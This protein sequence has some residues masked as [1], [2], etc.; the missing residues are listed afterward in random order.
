[1]PAESRSSARPATWLVIAGGGTGGHVVPGLTVAHELVARGHDPATIH[2]MGSEIGMEVDA[3]PTAGFGLTALPGRGLNSRRIDL[4]NLKAA[5]GL[6]RAGFAGVREVRRRH[7]A[8]VL[9]LGGFAAFAGIAGAVI[10]RCPLVVAEQ[11]AVAS[12]A[13]R[14][15]GR[16]ARVCAVSFEGTDLPRS[17]VTGNPVRTSIVDAGAVAADPR[18]R[19]AARAALGVG[20]SQVLVVA[21]S[22][23]LGSRTVNQAVIGMAGRLAD[24]GDLV[25]HHV[26]G[27]RDWQTPHAPSPAVAPDAAI[28]YRPVEYE[29]RPDQVLAAADLFI[30]R[31]GASTV[32]EL[33]VVGVPAILVPL[34]IAPRD[35]QAR[36]AEPFVRAG[37]ARVLSDAECTHDRLAEVVAELVGSPDQLSSMAVAM[38]ALGRPD[39]ARR[40]ADLIEEHARG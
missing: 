34:P 21:M 32:A 35:A 8:A 9:S 30:G 2:W 40:V 23:S 28:T 11:N 25:V 19:A 26:I 18:R 6:V 20:A 3:V 37:A 7:P 39:A 36:N 5:F 4:A 13:N 27:R 31:S 1:M 16:F 10:T 24:R 33:A 15:A 38:R 14:L 12:L 22:G 29:D 17:V